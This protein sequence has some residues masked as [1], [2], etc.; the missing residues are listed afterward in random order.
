MF[1]TEKGPEL[2]GKIAKGKSLVLFYATWCPDCSRFLPIFDSL[3][4]MAALPLRKA[5]I[6]RDENPMWDDFKIERV[7]TVVLFENGKE[8]GR[9]AESGGSIDA[10][11]LRKLLS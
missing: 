1:E 5:R 11:K 6:D 2:A 7:P 4:L 8:K 3:H 9:V 10:A